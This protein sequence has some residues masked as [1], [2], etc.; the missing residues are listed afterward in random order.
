LFSFAGWKWNSEKGWLFPGTWVY[1]RRNSGF[2]GKQNG[3]MVLFRAPVKVSWQEGNLN[4][5]TQKK[6]GLFSGCWLGGS[7]LSLRQELQLLV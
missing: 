6:T 5:R 7:S 4:L 1:F 3:M 2:L